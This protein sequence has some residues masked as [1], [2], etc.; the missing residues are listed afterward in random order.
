VLRYYCDCS[1]KAEWEV[2]IQ[3]PYIAFHWLYWRLNPKSLKLTSRALQTA[4]RD[5]NWNLLI[6]ALLSRTKR[7]IDRNLKIRSERWR[8]HS[9]LLFVRQHVYNLLV[10]KNSCVSM[11]D[12]TNCAMVHWFVY[13]TNTRKPHHQTKKNSH[14]TNKKFTLSAWQFP[15]TKITIIVNPY[16]VPWQNDKVLS[17]CSASAAMID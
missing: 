8:V 3:S 4:L 17:S 15:W 12:K 2:S 9:L 16:A 7:Y 6:N 13:A 10:N 11:C 5:T 1:D 14:S